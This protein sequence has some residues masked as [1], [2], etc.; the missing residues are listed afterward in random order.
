ML[1]I[2][3]KLMQVTNERLVFGGV[4]TDLV[5]MRDQPLHAMPMFKVHTPYSMFKVQ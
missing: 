1:Q 5:S 3:R 4:T 2:D